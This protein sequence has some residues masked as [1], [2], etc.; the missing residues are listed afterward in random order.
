MDCISCPHYHI[1]HYEDDYCDYC[2]FDKSKCPYKNKEN[3]KKEYRDMNCNYCIYKDK[4]VFDKSKCIHNGGNYSY[5]EATNKRLDKIEATIDK[6]SKIAEDLVSKNSTPL[7]KPKEL[8]C[9]DHSYHWALNKVYKNF[10]FAIEKLMNYY[11]FEAT[12]K[13]ISA[14]D[15][16]FWG[17]CVDSIMTSNSILAMKKEVEESLREELEK[18]LDKRFTKDYWDENGR[19]NYENDEDEVLF[20]SIWSWHGFHYQINLYDNL[21]VAVSV[22]YVVA[23]WDDSN[24]TDREIF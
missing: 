12:A 6:L 13:A 1:G 16:N 3:N 4:C 21:D 10:D 9:E 17:S 22:K 7:E 19:D 18:M 15:T 14:T 23:S 24:N 2:D 5:I 20:T 11:D 8:Q